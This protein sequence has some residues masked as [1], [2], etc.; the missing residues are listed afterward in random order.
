V[1]DEQ[2][3]VELAARRPRDAKCVEALT[4][5]AAPAIATASIASDLPRSLRGRRPD[6]LRARHPTR[7]DAKSSG[8]GLFSIRRTSGNAAPP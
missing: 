4:R 1:I 3:S 8:H 6:R 2:A 5:V 7:F